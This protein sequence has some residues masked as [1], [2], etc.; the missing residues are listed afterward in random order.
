M[1]QPDQWR[2]I[3]HE[4]ILYGMLFKAI[5]LNAESICTTQS[6]QMSLRYF[7]VAREGM[8]TYIYL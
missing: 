2:E 5:A 6:V 7:F 4:T 3:L 8:H 1:I